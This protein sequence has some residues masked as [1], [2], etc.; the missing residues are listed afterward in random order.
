MRMTGCMESLITKNKK[1]S[2]QF[3]AFC[4]VYGFGMYLLDIYFLVSNLLNLIQLGNTYNFERMDKG[5][6]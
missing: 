2:K 4:H 3:P 1:R 6:G 5:F